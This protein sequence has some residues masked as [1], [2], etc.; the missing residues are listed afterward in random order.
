M[1]VSMGAIAIR[2]ADK[3]ASK[4]EAGARKPA[5]L[6]AERAFGYLTKICDIGP[7]ISG[8]EGMDRQQ[9]LIS[10]HFTKLKANVR[11]QSFDAAHPASGNPVRMNN[12]IV[13]W[14]PAATKRVLL[15]CHY[16]TR[17]RA[18][19]DDPLRAREGKFLGAN[20]GASGVA[21]FMEL[22]HHIGRIKPT[23]GVDF[24]FFDG[25]ELVYGE[26]DP[27][28]LG[29][30]HFAKDYRDKP[31]QYEYVCGVLVDMIGD[32][33]LQLYEEANSLEYAPEVT[34]SI[35]KMA[36]KLGVKEFVAKPKHEVRDDHLPLNRIAHIP[37]CDIIDFDYPHWHTTRDVPAACSGES[38]AKV[39]RVLLAWLEEVPAPAQK[40]PKR[41]SR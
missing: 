16:D 21:L 27:Y 13:S 35:W 5:E 31:P 7:R 9:R 20:D 36:K 38:L 26:R 11:F 8:S 34:Q 4:G 41:K 19:R 39:G 10:E 23:Y 12:M 6:D 22:A 1:T 25:E 32:K 33:N 3:P 28:F 15:A 14:D 37:T 18:D 17:P 2:A 29:S 40:K 24:V 30:E